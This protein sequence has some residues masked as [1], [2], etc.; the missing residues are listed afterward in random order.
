M[1]AEIFQTEE[2]VNACRAITIS[3]EQADGPAEAWEAMNRILA[4]QSTSPEIGFV[5]LGAA[6]TALIILKNVIAEIHNEHVRKLAG[7]RKKPHTRKRYK[8]DRSTTVFS[9]T[10]KSVRL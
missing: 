4:D 9:R 8:L 1:S 10:F 6:D 2:I 5:A 7:L 3:L